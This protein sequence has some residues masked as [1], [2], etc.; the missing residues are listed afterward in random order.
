VSHRAAAH[1]ALPVPFALN[2][3]DMWS[4]TEDNL[5][6]QSISTKIRLNFHNPDWDVFW[7]LVAEEIAGHLPLFS[8]FWGLHRLGKLGSPTYPLIYI[9]RGVQRLITYHISP[10]LGSAAVFIHIFFVY[11]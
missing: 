5:L 9:P 11:L 7:N 3:P 2:V 6:V 8:F 10:S 4:R 1:V